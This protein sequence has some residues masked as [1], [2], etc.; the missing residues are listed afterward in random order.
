MT[1]PLTDTTTNA[2]VEA[3]FDP[4]PQVGQQWADHT[5]TWLPARHQ[6]V[7]TITSLGKTTSGWQAG[8][9][10]RQVDEDGQSVPSG[11]GDGTVH[12]IRLLTDFHPWPMPPLADP[13]KAAV[14]SL[15][16]WLY[17]TVQPDGALVSHHGEVLAVGNLIIGAA[18]DSA[19]LPV[20]VVSV[21][22]CRWDGDDPDVLRNPLAGPA[23]RDRYTALLGQLGHQVLDSWN[24]QPGACTG[25]LHLTRPAHPSLRAAQARY[26]AGC[27]EHPDKSVFCKCGWWVT[28]HQLLI[29]P[30]L[31]E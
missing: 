30:C 6:Q 8:V 13:V 24:W 2:L 16:A 3:G 26:R 27:T 9:T 1:A 31:T 20:I 11:C 5:V 7:V 15:L 4:V 28:G 12:V 22:K 29:K 10:R 21:G 14:R 23:E 19:G 18:A 17:D 25:S